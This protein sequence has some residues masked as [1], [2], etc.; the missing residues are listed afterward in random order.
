MAVERSAYSIPWSEA[1]MNDCLRGPYRC[2]VASGNGE[3]IAHMISQ[4]VVDELHLLNLCVAKQ[5]QRQGVGLLLLQHLF[6]TGQLQKARRLFL[7]LRSSNTAA[8]ALYKSMG[9]E[10][11]GE[12][13]DYYRNK[14]G[15]E[16]AV[17]MAADL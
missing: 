16:D 1:V 3:L 10:Q 11:I 17:V 5:H 9:F 14:A 7:E 13:R 8:L 12:R 4:L 15:R 6:D 2:E